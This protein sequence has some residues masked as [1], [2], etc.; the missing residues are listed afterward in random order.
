V[1][2]GSVIMNN[3]NN[4]ARGPYGDPGALELPLPIPY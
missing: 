3:G 4:T 2:L 1:F